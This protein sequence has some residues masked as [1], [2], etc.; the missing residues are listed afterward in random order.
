MLFLVL[1][2]LAWQNFS[3]FVKTNLPVKEL[4]RLVIH[5]KLTPDAMRKTDWAKPAIKKSL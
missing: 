4:N 1:R 5:R 2:N 3:D